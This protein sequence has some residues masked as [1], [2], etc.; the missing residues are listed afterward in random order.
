MIVEE[1]LK[2][3]DKLRENLTFT[4]NNPLYKLASLYWRPEIYGVE[5][6]PNN[7]A[8]IV[9]NHSGT[10][11][12][13]GIWLNTQIFKASGKT[14]YFMAHKI[15]ANQ[16]WIHEL[17]MILGER[18]T[19]LELLRRDKRV[20]VFPGGDDD[21][22][23]PSWNRYKVQEVKGFSWQYG[24]YL[25]TALATESPIVPV[26][27]IGL[28]EIHYNLANTKFL[29]KEIS[30][31]FGLDKAFDT[32]FLDH[33]GVWPIPLLTPPLPSKITI[34][35]GKPMNVIEDY[36]DFDYELFR[37]YL[38]IEKEKGITRLELTEM[39]NKIFNVNKKVRS[40]LQAMIDL[41]LEK[42]VGMTIN[43][44]IVQPEF[45]TNLE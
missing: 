32:K 5:N 2:N 10:L 39:R 42:R 14:T 20:G 29:L 8:V 41:A 6:I 36:P 7:R 23:K 33:I 3:E 31:Q 43:S 11:P 37:E 15:Y 1:I 16:K 22:F 13:D 44:K 24:G 35:C 26:A 12:M 27:V 25:T 9:A 18:E 17:G 21:L 45:I 28:E 34:L 19:A 30:S 38:M 4:I 40:R